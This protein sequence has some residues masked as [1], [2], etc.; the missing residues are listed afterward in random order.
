MFCFHEL[1]CLI[2]LL[3]ASAMESPRE[4]DVHGKE[5]CIQ[6]A[7]VSLLQS[8]L[9]MQ[10]SSQNA[11]S[12]SADETLQNGTTDVI[13]EQSIFDASF[14]NETDALM[15]SV[16]EKYQSIN[17]VDFYEALASEPDVRGERP[18]SDAVVNGDSMALAPDPDEMQSALYTAADAALLPALDADEPAPLAREYDPESPGPTLV[19]N[20][21]EDQPGNSEVPTSPFDS[22]EDQPAIA[23]G[24]SDLQEIQ[25]DADEKHQPGGSDMQ[26]KLDADEKHQPID[27][28][29]KAALA[30]EKLVGRKQPQAWDLDHPDSKLWTNAVD[31]E[32]WSAPPEA[33]DTVGV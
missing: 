25:R 26:I 18:T 27:Y 4:F 29:D 11:S 22:R 14:L 16:S 7:T 6:E 10:R 33:Y 30:R 8:K 17:P 15:R 20:S 32:V 13:E 3:G 24:H 1:I 5:S 19:P 9:E 2:A 31:D 28:N 12:G 21:Y 23:D